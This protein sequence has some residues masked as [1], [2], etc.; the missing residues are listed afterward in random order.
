MATQ[1]VK[2]RLISEQRTIDSLAGDDEQLR[3]ALA[4]SLD[5]AGQRPDEE[6]QLRDALAASLAES[7]RPAAEP[8]EQL[9]AAIRLS[10]QHGELP[11][12]L[13]G[14]RPC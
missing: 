13:S 10:L 14:R 4:A 8:D 5:G 12:P 2:P 1:P 3:D 7:A 11:H 9:R 6:S